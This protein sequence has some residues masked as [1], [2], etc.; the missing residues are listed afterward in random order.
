[1]CYLHQVLE[2]RPLRS[3]TQMSDS[4]YLHTLLSTLCKS[5]RQSTNE[6]IDLSHP[7]AHNFHFCYLGHYIW[8][9]SIVRWDSVWM[10]V[11]PWYIRDPEKESGNF[12]PFV[13]P[14]VYGS[15]P[16]EIPLVILYVVTPM[17]TCTF[18][19]IMIIT[20]MDSLNVYNNTRDQWVQLAWA[21]RTPE[22]WITVCIVL[23]FSCVCVCCV[24]ER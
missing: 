4:T 21:L 17:Q 13:I 2:R 24:C 18:I 15:T 7:H 3:S 14:H 19:T 6:I 8:S 22:P 1:M 9:S 10:W 11:A 23:H 20:P 16:M 12:S 5:V